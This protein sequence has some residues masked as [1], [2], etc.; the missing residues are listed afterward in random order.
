MHA[1]FVFNSR[2][3]ADVS[4]AVVSD[5]VFVASECCWIRELFTLSVILYCCI[6]T[7]GRGDILFYRLTLVRQQVNWC[8][9]VCMCVCGFVSVQE[10]R[11]NLI[12]VQDS[13]SSNSGVQLK[14]IKSRDSK[15]LNFGCPHKI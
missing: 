7:A 12:R 4:D 10:L 2:R 5:A 13:T 8:A 3:D 11:K 15:R 14:M 9:L 6:G 1:L